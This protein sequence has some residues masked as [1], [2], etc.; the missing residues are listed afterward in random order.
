VV[1]GG[2]V[3]VAGGVRPHA[4]GRPED[5]RKLP[6]THMTPSPH[7]REDTR[8]DAKRNRAEP[9][10]P[11]PLTQP[12]APQ[13]GLGQLSLAPQYGVGAWGLASHTGA[14]RVPLGNARRPYG[15]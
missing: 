3:D 15:M 6:R 8:T 4:R 9:H 14:K 10:P 1:H 12:T 13:L 11:Q 5:M 2:I 7:T